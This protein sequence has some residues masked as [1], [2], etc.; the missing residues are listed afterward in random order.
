MKLKYTDE[1]SVPV[2]L[3][4][5]FAELRRLQALTETKR[6]VALYE[7]LDDRLKEI[8][9]QALTSLSWHFEFELKQLRKE[10][11]DA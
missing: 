11:E 1:N 5:T 8:I 3:S 6:D 4:M 2:N 9:E 7:G 10:Q